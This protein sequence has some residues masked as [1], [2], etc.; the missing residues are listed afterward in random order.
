MEKSF[1]HN[2][3]KLKK[4]QKNKFKKYGEEFFSQTIKYK[5][6]RFKDFLKK[7]DFILN[8]FDLKRNFKDE[9]YISSYSF[10]EGKKESIKYPIFCKK[11]NQNF[12]TTITDGKYPSHCYLCEK[13]KAGTSKLEESLE[14][15]I[16]ELGIEY[17][18]NDRKIL[19]GKE[20]DFIFPEHNF[21]IELN[22]LYYHSFEYLNERGSDGKTYH[23]NKT[24]ICNKKKI[25]LLHINE[26]EWIEKRKTIK[27]M[28]KYNLGLINN[29]IN[30]RDCKVI[31]ISTEDAKKFLEKNHIQGQ[32]NSSIRLGL[33]FNEELVSLMTF[34]KNRYSDEDYEL[35]RFANK[36]N[37]NV[38]GGASKLFKY[39]LNNYNGSIMTFADRRY[40][41]GNLYKELGFKELYKTEPQY[42]YFKNGK[43]F[44]R[45]FFQKKNI[46]RMFNN[47]KNDKIHTVG[48]GLIKK[49]NKDLTGEDNLIL[50]R[51]NKIYDSGHI[52]YNFIREEDNDS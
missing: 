12:Y 6:K 16:L 31:N 38:R 1:L 37:T 50:N 2:Q 34:S 39:F 25:K 45:M 49:Y 21:A 22:G 29:K 35:V 10:D 42:K 14:K 30:A 33:I 19:N 40:S 24:E 26:N 15:F 41:E 8:E 27:S 43:V 13:Q 28:I 17:K 9:E 23:L 48:Y 7:L 36:L 47:Y 44:H 5:E 51:I 3:K 18:K 4:K 20:L 46:E 32:T 11:C 52:K